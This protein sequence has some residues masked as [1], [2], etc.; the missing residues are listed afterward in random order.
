MA[1]RPTVAEREEKSA[2]AVDLSAKGWTNTDIAAEIGVTRKTVA[3]WIANELSRRAEHRENDKERA[4]AVY[5]A[6]I[7]EGWRRL[8]NMDNRSLNVSGVLNS[9]RGA[10]DSI[11]KITGAE[12]PIKTDNRHTHVPSPTEREARELADEIAALE[13]EIH[14]EEA[15]ATG[16]QEGAG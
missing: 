10:Q 7:A 12:A 4:I 15:E 5:E 11:N 8:E 16:A 9:I 3:A 2:R 1:A 6:I 14:R 13:A